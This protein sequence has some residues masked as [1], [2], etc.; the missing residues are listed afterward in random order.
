MEG[1]GA[2]RLKVA[3]DSR[4]SAVAGAICAGLRERG[5]CEMQAIGAGAVNQAV[6]ALVV[7]RGYLEIE[8]VQLLFVPS[9]MDLDV[10]GLER[11]AVRFLVTGRRLHP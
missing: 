10:E 4:P 9:F 7:A 1:A 8:G 11:T 3:G 5:S 2:V 6:K